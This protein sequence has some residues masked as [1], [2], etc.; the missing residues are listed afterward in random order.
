[1]KLVTLGDINREIKG[2]GFSYSIKDFA[3]QLAVIFIAVIGA[4]ILFSLKI[5]FIAFCAIFMFVLIPYVYKAQ[6]RFL[7][8]SKKFDD[9]VLYMTQMISSFKK[10]NKILLSLRETRDVVD[11]E[12]GVYIDEAIEYLEEGDS[13]GDI[14]REA[15]SII[16][17]RYGCGRMKSL[18]DFLT[19]VET[20]GGEYE[21]SLSIL[22]DDIEEWAGRTYLYQKDR[23]NVRNKITL[24]IG[25][26]FIIC[27]VSKYMIPEKFDFTVNLFY[28]I[29]TTFAISSMCLFYTIVQSVVVGSWLD[30]KSDYD[31][32]KIDKDFKTLNSFDSHAAKIK[33]LPVC[34]LMVGLAVY[35]AITDNM[36]ITIACIAGACVLYSQPDKKVKSSRKR[37]EREIQKAFPDWLRGLSI[38]LQTKTV[39]VAIRDSLAEA[40]YILRSYIVDMMKKF[41]EG[42]YTIAPYVEFAE[43]FKIKEVSS[44][45]R[46]LYSFNKASR[47]ESEQQINLLIKRNNEMLA[48]SEVLRNEDVTSICGFMV[49]MPMMI[50][51]IKL[52]VDMILM[53]G[54]FM[55][56]M[57]TF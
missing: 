28:Q 45:M 54:S 42:D 20:A 14:Y 29:A 7:Y 44:A 35:Y 36:S 2:C 18:H 10:N 34:L 12:I 49:M 19:K 37:L 24:A 43:E 30:D 13:N 21:S 4:G 17:E 22:N 1:M 46:A 8:E 16:E 33:Y 51:C 3:K 56:Q 50:G 48:K 57:G 32:N 39:R 25:L 6:F 27:A 26:S 38:S 55:S 5:P 47:E 23:K 52:V 53:F 15:L 11:D 31:A 9:A 40:P 41:D